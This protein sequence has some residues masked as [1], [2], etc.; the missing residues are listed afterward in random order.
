M[1]HR[2]FF[3]TI[4]FYFIFSVQFFLSLLP[5]TLGNTAIA[6]SG[7]FLLAWSPCMWSVGLTIVEGGFGYKEKAIAQNDDRNPRMPLRKTG[8]RDD[9]GN[10]A[11]YEASM[12][13][14][15]VESEGLPSD[16]CLAA[17]DE[18]A[19]DDD[20]KEASNPYTSR[21]GLKGENSSQDH[22]YPALQRVWRILASS[23]LGSDRNAQNLQR[24]AGA[25]VVF[26]RRVLN[27]PVLAIIAGAILGL[28]PFGKEL[29][30]MVSGI[31]RSSTASIGDSVR[32]AQL[33]PELM[34]VQSLLRNAYEVIEMLAAGT[35]GMQTLVLASS[36]LQRVQGS[37]NG[38]G[39]EGSSSS[40]TSTSSPPGAES[41]EPT[42]LSAAWKAVAPVDGTEARALFVL[43]C[44]RFL[45]LPV[46]CLFLW[47][48]F[49]SIALTTSGPLSGLVHSLSADPLFLFI[50]AVQSVMPSAQNLIIMLQL[51]PKT[52]KAAPAFARMLLKLY[53]YA[54]LPVTLWVTAYA[55]RLAV[56]L[57]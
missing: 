46:T 32:I 44:V 28:T 33:P 54:V 39:S 27:P 43:S 23:F 29:Y 37:S 35:L 2:L 12:S 24:I 9:E 13:Q 38:D 22:L 41:S 7:L 30:F 16:R 19:V 52:Q 20:D 40:E 49:C 36:L 8:T 21:R 6:Y 4:Y 51:S 31:S 47:K 48:W 57:V 25:V 55:S 10:T 5:Q 14:I 17:G 11:S 18:R 42:I 3:F 56:P 53:A 15:D 50:I 26:L 1:H 34:L 45:L